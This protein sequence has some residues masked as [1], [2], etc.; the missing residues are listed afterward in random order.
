MAKLSSIIS[1]FARRK[2]ILLSLCIIT[3]AGFLFK[4]YCGPAH[5]WFNN[6]GAGLLYEV[7]WCLSVFCF[8]PRKKH[9]TP[10]AVSVFIA[11]SILEILQ[12]WQPWFLQNARSTFLGKALLCTTFVWCDFPHY[13]LGCLIG[14]LCMR[15]LSKGLDES[16]SHY[17]PAARKHPD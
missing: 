12:L 6:Y 9:A 10:I 7:F 4:S 2:W 14:W 16:D 11:T 17:N 15:V 1:F 13:L 3:P 5:R 8:I